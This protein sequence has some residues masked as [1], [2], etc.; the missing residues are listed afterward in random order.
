MVIQIVYCLPNF[1]VLVCNTITQTSDMPSD[2]RPPVFFF[3]YLSVL[4]DNNII[5]PHQVTYTVV[6]KQ[7][8]KKGKVFIC[9]LYLCF[10]ELNTYK[11][12]SM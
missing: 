11:N 5:D 10:K 2:P 12:N 7:R 3:F 6:R 8:K 9:P 1:P 4:Q